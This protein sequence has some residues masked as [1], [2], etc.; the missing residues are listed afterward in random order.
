MAV[1]IILEDFPAHTQYVPL[2]V[3]GYCLTRNAFL[4]PVWAPISWTMKTHDHTPAQKLQD[5]L[6]S[7]M[8][9]NTSVAQIGLPAKAGQDVV[10][11]AHLDQV[12]FPVT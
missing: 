2:A 10:T 12:S 1:T 11:M 7:I 4:S 9:G 8:A 5:M 6:V 3:L